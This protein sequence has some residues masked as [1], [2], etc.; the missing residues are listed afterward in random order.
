MPLDGTNYVETK[1]DLVPYRE[2]LA[3]AKQYIIEHG[4]CQYRSVGYQGT[5]CLA[6][7]IY[8]VAPAQFNDIIKQVWNYTH[9][10]PVVWN[11]T[12]GRTKEEVLDLLTV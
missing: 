8:L 11:D 10:D 2:E 3:K 6:H 12:P 4:W 9:S 1:Q 7:A 5:V